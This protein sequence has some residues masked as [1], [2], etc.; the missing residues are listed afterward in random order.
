[1]PQGQPEAVQEKPA[2][3]TLPGAVQEK[4][5]V[6]AVRTLH[7]TVPVYSVDGRKL[8]EEEL[9]EVFSSDFEPELIERAVL[10]IQSARK[11]SQGVKPRAGRDNTAEYRGS[12]NLPFTG[13]TIN[14]G[15]ARLPRMKNRRTLIAG[16]V[17][18]IPRA[19]GGPKAHPP[20]AEKKTIEKINRKEKRKALRSALASTR[21]FSLVSR[22]HLLEKEIALPLVVE[23]KFEG[24]SKTKDVLKAFKA[25]GISKDLESAK[26]KTKRK[27]GKGR[28]R[29]RTKKKK[30]SILIVTGKKAAVYRAARNLVGVDITPLKGL[31][32]ELLAPGGVPGR[33]TVF[34]ESALDALR[35]WQGG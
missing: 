17:A 11:Q 30:K 25:I 23:D 4:P 12:R 19:V 27:S 13:R 26:K 20:K 21:D 28:R 14:I 10:S 31:N 3:K 6:Q 7:K 8:K 32:A 2:G 1:M 24:F 5:A 33:L 18:S 34:T 16:R 35:K 22:R 29:G 9:P 15:R